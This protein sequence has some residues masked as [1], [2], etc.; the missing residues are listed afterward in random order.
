MKTLNPMA[1]A[2]MKKAIQAPAY[3]GQGYTRP[4]RRKSTS[5][6]LLFRDQKA[7]KSTAASAV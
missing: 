3:V 5:R 4:K 7:G 1:H 6:G 2:G